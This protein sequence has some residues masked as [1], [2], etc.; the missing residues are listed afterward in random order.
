MM[1]II[2]SP[3]ALVQTLLG[4]LRTPGTARRPVTSE[5]IGRTKDTLVLLVREQWSA[6]ARLRSLDDPGPLPVE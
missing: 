5:D 6:E 4:P 2:L 1:S 3:P